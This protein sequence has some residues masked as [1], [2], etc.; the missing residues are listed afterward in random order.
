MGPLQGVRIVEMSNIGP[1]PFCGMLLADLGAEVV[2]V[3]RLS[4]G[5]LGFDIGLR[6]DL[7]NR[8]KQAA[9]VD[10]KSPEGVAVVREM[11][12]SA[13]MVIEGFRPGV[14]E[15]LG[16]GPEVCLADNPR[17]VYGR[18]TG[19]GQDGPLAQMAG[20]DINY[21][22][23]TGALAAIG[24]KGGAPAVPLNLVGDFA[25]G[26]LYLAMGLLAA[27]V[28]ARQSGRG[29]VVDA[30][31]VDGVASM[32]TMH[33][34]YRQAK[35]WNLDRGTNSVDGGSPWYTTYATKDGRWMAVGAVET[36]FYREF[37][38]I[39][40]LDVATLPGQH[41]HTRWDELR[42]IFAT[43]FAKKTRDEWELLFEGTDA[44]V[45]PVLD[46]DEAPHHRTANARGTFVQRDGLTEPAPAPRFSRTAAT[47]RNSPPD[48]RQTT[49]STLS[50]W[51]IDPA[52]IAR[53]SADGVIAAPD[54]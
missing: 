10:L 31:M 8:S 3:Q 43:E 34:G 53:L 9:A 19:W 39:L 46:M 11:I 23:M 29:Q 47:I 12:A 30:A 20:H 52:R 45:S 16:L 35:F 24:P 22:A 26:S 33:L 44:C 5:D 25:G 18:M 40:G 28:E 6:Y 36:R 48:A 4:T 41:D 32:L 15:R 13:D 7:L 51:G 17:L 50:A 21:I 54:A 42:T 38:R 2:S 14:M 49:A 37:V 27:L 1:G